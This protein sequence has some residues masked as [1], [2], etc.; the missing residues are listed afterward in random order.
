MTSKQCAEKIKVTINDNDFFEAWS[1]GETSNDWEVP[2]FEKSEA[3]KVARLHNCTYDAIKD[4]Y[5]FEQDG[6]VQEYEGFMI[7]TCEG[8]KKVYAIGSDG[9]IWDTK[10]DDDKVE[11]ANGVEIC[12]GD[13]LI[14]SEDI[15]KGYADGGRTPIVVYKKGETVVADEVFWDSSAMCGK[16]IIEGK[17]FD[18]FLFLKKI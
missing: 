11:D 14:A 8:Q 7:E 12:E 6:E 1:F 9:W 10:S 3:D 18:G 5:C 16:V 15:E 17:D 2:H 4:A 13:T